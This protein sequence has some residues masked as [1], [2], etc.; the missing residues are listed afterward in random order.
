MITITVPER[1]T[2]SLTPVEWTALADDDAFWRLVLAGIVTAET[3]K[4]GGWQ[5]RGSCYVGRTLVGGCLLEVKEKFSGSYEKLLSLGLSR[6][7]KYTKTSSPVAPDRNSTSL[8]ISLFIMSAKTY[9][10]GFKISE[11]EMREDK[12]TLAS[13]RLNIRRTVGLRSRGLS[14][15]VAFTRSVLTADLDINRIIYAALREVGVVARF[16]PINRNDVSTARAL[17]VTLSEC[18]SSLWNS[19][20]DLKERATAFS[21][22]KDIHPVARD[23][24]S[25]AAAVL[26]AAGFGGAGSW[27]KVVGRSWFV[28]LETQF[29]NAVRAEIKRQL[30]TSTVTGAVR[31]PPLFKP[32]PGRYAANPDVV[33]A[34]GEAIM[35]IGDAKYKEFTIWPSASDVHELLAHSAAYGVKRAFFVFPHEERYFVKSLGRA[36]TGCHIWVFGV[37]FDN[38]EDDI[39]RLLD[40]MALS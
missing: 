33:I 14:H 23:A 1:G 31:R 5:L 35:A 15:Q 2:A 39:G 11:Y 22:R 17:A 36:P 37:T 8:L 18:R 28:N 3:R 25:L 16:V 32:D 38:F 40:E 9:L 4:G 7:P 10:S 13:G 27:A 19:V 30:H 34:R 26:D 21:E 6:P 24:V 20:D 12:G 29:E